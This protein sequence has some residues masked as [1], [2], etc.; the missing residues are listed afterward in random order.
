[1]I[2]VRTVFAFFRNY[3]LRW[4]ILD[5]KSG[6]QIA[7]ITSNYTHTKYSLLKKMNGGDMSCCD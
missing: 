4:G 6:W 3:F 7:L 5:G 2:S 1:M